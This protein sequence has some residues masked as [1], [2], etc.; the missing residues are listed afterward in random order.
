MRP[1]SIKL[2]SSNYSPRPHRYIVWYSKQILG[3]PPTTNLAPGAVDVYAVLQIHKRDHSRYNLQG[4]KV[5]E[6]VIEIETPGIITRKYPG[7]PSHLRDYILSQQVRLC[8]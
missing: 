2:S 4:Q 5:L 7:L 8:T 6:K 3:T 1:L